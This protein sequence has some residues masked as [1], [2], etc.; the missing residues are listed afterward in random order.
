LQH[1]FEIIPTDATT[2][3]LVAQRLDSLLANQPIACISVECECSL[4]YFS[5]AKLKPCDISTAAFVF[6]E[7]EHLPSNTLSSGRR[8]NVHAPQFHCVI[9][10]AFEAESAD[11]FVASDGNPTLGSYEKI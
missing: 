1:L 6:R 4:L 11:H 9:G 2:H 10:G 5:S 3:C 7:L 8:M